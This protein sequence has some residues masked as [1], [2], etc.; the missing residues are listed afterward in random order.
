MSET[1]HQFAANQA[2][3]SSNSDG[4]DRLSSKVDWGSDLEGSLGCDET[5][6]SSPP[7]RDLPPP[8]DFHAKDIVRWTEEPVK[9][10]EKFQATIKN[11][12]SETIGHRANRTART[13]ET[14]LDVATSNDSD[15][16]SLEVEFGTDCD[17][18]SNSSPPYT[19]SP[20]PFEHH[21]KGIA[22]WTAAAAKSEENCDRGAECLIPSN[23]EEAKSIVHGYRQAL[24]MNAG[25]STLHAVC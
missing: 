15:G 13:L 23:V 16:L 6:D 10:D 22:S 9:S 21:V 25:T 7:Y 4:I 1:K 24:G 2:P 11:L 17:E 19:G 14:S 12:A 8:F 20:A 5:S 3:P 18:A